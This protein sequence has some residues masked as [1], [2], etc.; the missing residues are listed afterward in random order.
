MNYL[1]SEMSNPLKTCSHVFW[2]PYKCS[3]YDCEEVREPHLQD[4][5]VEKISDF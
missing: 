1:T 4:L 2:A 5:Q 3:K